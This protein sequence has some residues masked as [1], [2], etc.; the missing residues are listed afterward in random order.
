MIMGM[1]LSGRVHRCSCPLLYTDESLKD[2]K[3]QAGGFRT[4]SLCLISEPQNSFLRARMLWRTDITEVLTMI[5]ICDTSPG[6][7]RGSEW[8][9]KWE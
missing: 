4:M 9:Q 6:W 7:T 3:G 1:L 2:K 8:L 5:P